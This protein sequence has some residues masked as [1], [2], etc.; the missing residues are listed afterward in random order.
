[1]T[2]KHTPTFPRRG[3]R[4]SDAKNLALSNQEGAGN[5]GCALHPAVSRAN[6][7]K[8][9]HEHTGAAEA[10]RHSL[11]NGFTAYSG[12]S[13]ATGLVATIAPEKL[14]LLKNLTPASGRQDHTASP[15]ARAQL[16]LEHPGVHRIP[17]HVRDD[18]ERPSVGAG[19]GE[20]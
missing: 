12:L 18:R 1:M 19:R 2:P 6:A 20:L 15:Y 3:L 4:P 10:I 11:R 8:N 13:L 9:A 5:A 16:V 14:S 17:P 7:Q